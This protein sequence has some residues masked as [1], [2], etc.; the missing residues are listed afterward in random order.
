MQIRS[1]SEIVRF[2]IDPW[3]A[4]AGK[5]VIFL[6][7]LE[8]R[9]LPQFCL[10]FYRLVANFQALGNTKTIKGTAWVAQEAWECLLRRSKRATLS[11]K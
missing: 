9:F 8:D 1:C 6:A 2:L 5:L 7:T 4:F 11:N 10:Y 3:S